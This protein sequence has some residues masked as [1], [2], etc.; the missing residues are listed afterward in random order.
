LTT[1][2]CA[3]TGGTAGPL[4]AQGHYL[5]SLNESAKRAADYI[6]KKSRLDK[7]HNDDNNL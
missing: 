7:Q 5:F 3:F 4:P 6:K 2:A 1:A